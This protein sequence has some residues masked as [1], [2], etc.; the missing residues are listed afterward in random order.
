M[1][2]K[3]SFLDRVL[4]GSATALGK[5]VETS[6]YAVGRI[7]PAVQKAAKAIADTKV[8]VF[9]TENFSEGYHKGYEAAIKAEATRIARKELVEAHKAEAGDEKARK[10]ADKKVDTFLK[11]LGKDAD[12]AEEFVQA[13]WRKLT[14]NTETPEVATG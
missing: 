12:N 7:A 10:R 8:G 1:S 11:T 13:L 14:G 2:E 4:D 3:T 5:G 9:M 6:G